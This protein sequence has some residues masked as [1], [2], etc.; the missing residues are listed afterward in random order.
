MG[1]GFDAWTSTVSGAYAMQRNAMRGASILRFAP[2]F[3]LP[4]TSNSPLSPFPL[5][6]LPFHNPLPRLNTLSNKSIFQNF[7]TNLDRLFIGTLERRKDQT[8]R[9]NNPESSSCSADHERLVKERG[10]EVVL[11]QRIQFVR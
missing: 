9:N 8:P 10:S 5:N 3:H 1:L 2:D 4:S 7:L 6:F 11:R